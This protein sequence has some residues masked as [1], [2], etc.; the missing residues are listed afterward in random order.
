MPS[1]QMS[2]QSALCRGYR[3]SLRPEMLRYFLIWLTA[4]ETTVTKPLKKLILS[5]DRDKL[6]CTWH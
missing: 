5:K 4:K 6:K 3:N 2:I 1:D